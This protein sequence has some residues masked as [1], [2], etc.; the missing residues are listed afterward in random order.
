MARKVT[1]ATVKRKGA[2]ISSGTG[3]HKDKR[4]RRKRTRQAQQQ[5]A[6]EQDTQ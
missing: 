3:K 2:T 6:Q 5:A 4:T 1:M